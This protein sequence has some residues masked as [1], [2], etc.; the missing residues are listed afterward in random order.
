VAGPEIVT[1]MLQ[2]LLDDGLVIQTGSDLR[3]AASALERARQRVVHMAETGQDVTV[4][5]LRDG[6]G[7]SRRYALAVLE[8]FD[9]VRVTRRIG[10][11]RVLG[12]NAGAS[13][14][15]AVTP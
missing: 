10:D 4:A 11:R 1:R 14:V 9:A 13:L 5:S 2:T 8:Y 3:F 15:P 12:P 7:T 6:L